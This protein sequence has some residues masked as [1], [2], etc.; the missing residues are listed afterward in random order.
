M[1]K[2]TI[3]KVKKEIRRI[4]KDTKK[5]G[6]RVFENLLVAAG[7]TANDVTVSTPKELKKAIDAHCDR[8]IITEPLAKKR[9]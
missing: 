3:K 7:S 8:I 2:K 1:K 6:T 4:V 9:R 5:E